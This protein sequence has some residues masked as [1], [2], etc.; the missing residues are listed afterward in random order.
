MPR[1]TTCTRSFNSRMA[2][3]KEVKAIFFKK[4]TYF[5]VKAESK[6]YLPASQSASHPCFQHHRI[7][8]QHPVHNTKKKTPPDRN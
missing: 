1:V 8:E 6:N 3:K 5:F 2:C 7:S 4:K